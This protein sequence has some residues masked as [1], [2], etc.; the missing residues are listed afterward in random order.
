MSKT[1]GTF[2]NARTYLD[3]LPPD[4]LR[5]YYATKLNGRV[6]DLDLSF[7]DFVNRVNAELVNKIANLAS[8]SM[9]FVAKRLDH[10][11]G[12]LPEDAAPLLKQAEEAVAAATEAYERRDVAAAISRPSSSPRR[13]TCTFRARPPGTR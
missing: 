7:E 12:R 13:A 11:L 5:Y 10:K 2:I 3:H 6:E 9:S 4:Y 8:R 1:R